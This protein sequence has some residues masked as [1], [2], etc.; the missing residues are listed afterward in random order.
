MPG[1]IQPKPI[2]NAAPLD[3]IRGLSDDQIASLRAYWITSVQEFLAAADLPAGVANLAS[4]LD[5]DE[6]RTETLIQRARQAVPPSRGKEKDLEDEAMAIDYPAGAI[7]PTP[8]MRAG[9][10]YETIAFAGELPSRVDYSDSLPPPRDQG[11]RGTC[12]AHAAAAVRE[13]LEIQYLET[14]GQSVDVDKINLSEQFIYWWCKERDNLPRVSGTYPQLG[15]ECL[16]DIGAPPENDWPYNP[17]VV[18]GDE[19]QGPPPEVAIEDAWRYRVKRVIQL[20][21]KDVD[22]I[23]TALAD[24]K[25][26]LFAIPIFNSWYRNRMTRRFGKINMP[27]PNERPNG[28]HAMAIIGYVDD[29]ETPGG[30]YFLVRNSWAP[31]GYDNPLGESIGSI[32][33]AFISKHNMAASTGDRA[34]FSDVYIRDNEEDAGEVPSEGNKYNSPDIWVRHEND[35]QEGHQTPRG[36]APN[37][38]Y[39]RAWNLGPG[40]A[41]GVRG[42]L[43]QSPVSPSIWPNNWQKIG[44]IIFPHIPLGESAISAL[45]WTP[46]DDGPFCFLAQLHSSDDPLQH[47]WSVRND[48]NVAQKNLIVLQLGPGEKADFSFRMNGLPGK[49][50]HMD[51]SVNRKAFPRGRVELRMA[52]RQGARGGGKLIE[53]EAK[54]ADLAVKATDYEDIGVTITADQ[55]ATPGETG[56]I[57][58]TQTY[59]RLLVGRVVVQV[60]IV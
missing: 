23:K 1:S 21:P 27:M 31:W 41:K 3:R 14:V 46:A 37:W 35:G 38:I 11:R 45:V 59:G 8:Q 9:E 32:P 57:V 58:F 7:E 51:L 26:V 47:E 49:V 25:A 56:E 17:A 4:I 48:N 34:S 50:T 20:D 13:F 12:V 54:L 53:D 18:T 16:A 39:V 42:T 2:K 43:Y 24:G 30:G 33:Y 5:V 36:G 60:E 15:I 44:E 55:R 19:G 6:V 52:D 28:A 29:E 40:E 22:S 10:K